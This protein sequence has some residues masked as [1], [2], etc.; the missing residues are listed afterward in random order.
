MLLVLL[1]LLGHVDDEVA[2]YTRIAT[3]PALALEAV[4]RLLYQFDGGQ[5]GKVLGA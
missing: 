4:L 1:A 3:Q 5:L 2:E